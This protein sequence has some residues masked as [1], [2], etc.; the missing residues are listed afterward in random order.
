MSLGEFSLGWRTYGA[1][2]RLLESDEPMDPRY[3]ID[4]FCY[5]CRACAKT[6]PVSMFEFKEEE[7]IL[8]NDELHPRGKRNNLDLC[9]ISC[10]GL[11]ALSFEKRWTSWGRYWIDEWVDKQPDLQKFIN[12]RINL[13]KK[14]METGTSYKRYELLRR[15]AAI[16]WPEEYYKMLPAGDEAPEDEEELVRIQKEYSNK[17]GI[18]GLDD[19]NV[20]TC[21][22]CALV[23]GPTIDENINRLNMLVES[24]LVIPGENGK[25][26]RVDTFEQAQEIRKKY[27]QKP[28]SAQLARDVLKSSNQW[29]YFYG[30]IQPKSVFKGI[31]YDRK[32]KQA[33]KEKKKGFKVEV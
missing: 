10:F 17:L 24:G 26:V 13:M 4:N 33:V 6:C 15:M 19:Y 5:K 23:C 2:R 16:R 21:G 22:Q 12:T 14:G 18:D 27:P 1:A 32:L 29:P 25:M 9:N 28:G 11:H 20:L 30:G 7:Y 3:F 31:V 8:I